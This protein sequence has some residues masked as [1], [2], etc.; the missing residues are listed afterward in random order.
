[1]SRKR[2]FIDKKGRMLIGWKREHTDHHHEI[3]LSLWNETY[4]W[5]ILTHTWAWIPNLSLGFYFFI[6]I[7]SKINYF[8]IE[9]AT[10]HLIE[11]YFFFEHKFF[12]MYRIRTRTLHWIY[13]TL[14]LLTNKH[15][16]L[17]LKLSLLF[18]SQQFFLIH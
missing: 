5:W 9:L 10:Y 13:Y 14:S 11:N 8:N 18:L 2:L 12:F 17:E 1:M 4:Q 7:F 3:N 6:L 15:K 16:S